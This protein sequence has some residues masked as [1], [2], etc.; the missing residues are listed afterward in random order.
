MDPQR[1]KLFG[2]KAWAVSLDQFAGSRARLSDEHA[3]L[4]SAED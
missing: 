4:R 3:L 1:Y 2:V